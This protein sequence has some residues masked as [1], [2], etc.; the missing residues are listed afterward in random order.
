MN[1]KLFQL[2]YFFTSLQT[3][4]YLEF[5]ILRKRIMTIQKLHEILF[6]N[7]NS[8]ISEYYKPELNNIKW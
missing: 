8:F 6:N 7:D 4:S 2:S 1:E 5:Y 3:V